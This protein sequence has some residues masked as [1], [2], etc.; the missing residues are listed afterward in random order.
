ML[1]RIGYID[2]RRNVVKAAV[3]RWNYDCLRQ[4]ERR[5]ISSVLDWWTNLWGEFASKRF[6]EQEAVAIAGYVATESEKE[7]NFFHAPV[8]FPKRNIHSHFETLIVL[9]KASSLH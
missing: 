1:S 8:F 4:N 5:L 3:N 9:Q 6:V 7:E 2:S